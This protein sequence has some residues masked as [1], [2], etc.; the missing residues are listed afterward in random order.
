[1]S[2]LKKSFISGIAAL[3]ILCVYQLE[4]YCARCAK[5]EEER[6]RE[7]AE[8]PQEW[9]YYDDERIS[10][11]V[12]NEESS[13]RS[14]PSPTS[15]AMENKSRQNPSPQKQSFTPP[16]SQSSSKNTLG[17]NSD[18]SPSTLYAFAVASPSTG[19]N[20]IRKRDINSDVYQSEP[21]RKTEFFEEEVSKPNDKQLNQKRMDPSYL[22]SSLSNQPAL[23]P[24]V[25]STLYT[26]FS[27]KQFLE[28]LD[29]SFTLLVPTDK[30][31]QNLPN[32]LLSTLIQA[33]NHEQLSAIVSNHIIPRKILKKDFEEHKNQEIKAIS[34]R[35]LTLSSK[36][37]I[38]MIDEAQILRIEPAGYDGVIYVIDRLLLP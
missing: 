15:D 22:P 6:A 32:S 28:T 31:I 36:N 5:I 12:N 30:A 9:G 8:H 20:E 25:Y 34:G 14:I 23:P 3:S 38:P 21:S 37:G 13:Q 1:M 33:E 24:S 11:R 10:I 17:L 19:N 2:I 27:T 18:L 26:I 4:A 7:K 16:S 29:G 35:N